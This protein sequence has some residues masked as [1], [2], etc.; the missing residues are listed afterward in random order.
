MGFRRDG[1]PPG[2]RNDLW[3]FPTRPGLCGPLRELCGGYH[4]PYWVDGL[5]VLDE[6]SLGFVSGHDDVGL[7]TGLASNPSVCGALFVGPGGDGY[8][9]AFTHARGMDMDGSGRIDEGAA[10]PFWAVLDELAA[11]VTRTRVSF[12]LSVMRAGIVMDPAISDSRLKAVISGFERWLASGGA[13]V[14]HASGIGAGRALALAASG[15]QIIVHATESADARPCTVPL[16]T[17]RP[18]DVRE[19]PKKALAS[20]ALRFLRTASGEALAPS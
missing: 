20:L 16:I 19:A 10:K 6:A 1:R 9:K 4:V 14:G 5:Y 3:V 12:G 17:L 7:L 15:A 13:R 18:S 8:A 2:V 11:G